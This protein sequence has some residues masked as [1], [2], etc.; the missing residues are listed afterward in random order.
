MDGQSFD[1]APRRS[2]LC[3]Q[4]FELRVAV[5][6]KYKVGGTCLHWGCIPTKVI[7]E[8]AEVCSMARRGQ[9]FGVNTGSVTLIFSGIKR[10][11]GSSHLPAVEFCSKTWR[12]PDKG[13]EADLATLCG[14]PG[15]RWH[16][17][18]GQR[19]H[20]R[21]RL[22]SQRAAGRQDRRADH[23]QRPR[24]H[25]GR[26]SGSVICHRGRGHRRGIRIDWN[27]A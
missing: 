22:Y 12:Y 20:H 10:R 4:V 9:E 26:A 19:R 23:Q 14:N 2:S 15:R 6:E 18:C 21:H 17:R 25:H 27:V 13:E 16:L 3:Y 1:V 8:S 5:I 7:L 11:E 24:I